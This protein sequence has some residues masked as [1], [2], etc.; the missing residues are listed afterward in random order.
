MIAPDD[1]PLAKDFLSNA[2][3]ARFPSAIALAEHLGA[4]IESKRH[5]GNNGEQERKIS[6]GWGGLHASEESTA[7]CVLAA[8]EGSSSLVRLANLLLNGVNEDPSGAAY[9]AVAEKLVP[10]AYRHRQEAFEAKRAGLPPPPM[11]EIANAPRSAAVPRANPKPPED[12]A[13][14]WIWKTPED[15][16]AAFA[17]LPLAGN[18][19]AALV[20]F[21]ADYGIRPDCVP[22][23]WRVFVHPD[24]GPGVVYPGKAI[25]GS[26]VYKFKSLARDDRGKRGSRFLHGAA[27]AF[28]L[29]G[30]DHAPVVIVA[31]E[32]KAAAAH[33][34]GFSAIC[35]LTGEKGLSEEWARAVA[36][37][38]PLCIVMANDAD[39]VGND[40][41][42]KSAEALELAGV[43]P[44][45][46]RII[47]WPEWAP[48]GYDLS[49][50]FK[51]SG[52]SGVQEL[53]QGARQWKTE[54]APRNISAADY[55]AETRPPLEYHIEGLLHR[56]GK[57][58]L[59]AT[60]KAGK[61]WWAMEIGLAM[62]QGYVS[63]LNW[64]IR[65]PSKIFYV[66]AEI[67]DDLLY[68]RLQLLRA[69]PPE[70]IGPDA[71]RRFILREIGSQKPNIKT[72]L[73]RADLKA[74]IAS[75][76]PD[77]LILDPLCML[78][79]GLNENDTETMGEV[80]DFL[81]ELTVGDNG[82]AIILVHHH[83]KGGVSRG[84]SVYEGWGDTDLSVSPTDKDG[85]PGVATVKALLRC[86]PNDGD[87]Y[88]KMPSRESLWI[89]P[90]ATGWTP[91]PKPG[92]RPPRP[93]PSGIFPPASAS[94]A[95]PPGRPKK[96]P[97]RS[98][99]LMLQEMGGGCSQFDLTNAYQER[100]DVSLR[101]AQRDLALATADG[102]IIIEGDKFIINKD[103]A[104]GVES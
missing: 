41:N 88:W 22:D 64:E 25:D 1:G 74:R 99:I 24:A 37:L 91:P 66:Q 94:P 73:G 68:E 48:S 81:A 87:A 27:G 80:L 31:G 69:R 13:K 63:F 47:Q 39:S 12:R 54:R 21:E 100:F 7:W 11:R 5:R 93:A 43:D 9:F 102:T 89:A 40:A 77:V 86:S 62:A 56:R 32:E 20:V 33:A 85:L 50:A 34:S 8:K 65:K 90:M 61:S 44:R 96:S 38:A 60:A 82:V 42:M 55:M 23:D 10:D 84:S 104:Y 30:P 78:C 6:G 46:I 101:T 17:A 49:D 79:P 3:A 75:V 15:A 70:W 83:G 92:T 72:M 98:V 59:S 35:P 26:P 4:E 19:D 16:F 14:N 29:K 28:R 76:K 51:G 45:T 71:W 57:M 52:P 97:N 58:T 103:Y 36:S 18:D 95:G 53:I 2:I 67:N